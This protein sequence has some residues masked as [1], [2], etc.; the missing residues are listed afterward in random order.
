MSHPFR[1]RLVLE[2]V[3]S[4]I[5]LSQT[6]ID[7]TSSSDPALTSTET[8]AAPY[9]SIDFAHMGTNGVVTECDQIAITIYL[10]NGTVATTFV[11]FTQGITTPAGLATLAG[12]ALQAQGYTVN[13]NGSVL[14]IWG[15]GDAARVENVRVTITHSPNHGADYNFRLPRVVGEN[16]ATGSAGVNLQSSQDN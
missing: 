6:P 10:D 2:Q 7:P 9:V 1:T 16:G 12:A 14:V 3:E 13:Y 8:E 4:R 5:A 11:N 15:Q